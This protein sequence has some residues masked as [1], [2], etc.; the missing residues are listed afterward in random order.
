MLHAA[1]SVASDPASASRFSRP[2]SRQR[3]S[4]RN[5]AYQR[6]TPLLGNKGPAESAWKP[7]LMGLSSPKLIVFATSTFANEKHVMFGFG[8]VFCTLTCKT[9]RERLGYPHVFAQAPPAG[10][11]RGPEPDLTAPGAKRPLCF[12]RLRIG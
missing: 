4:L 9:R 12:W 3:G 1:G 11:D 8:P 2:I 10:Q 7:S 5:S 6:L